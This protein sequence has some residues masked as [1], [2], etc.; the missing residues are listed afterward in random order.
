MMD[1]EFVVGLDA[2]DNMFIDLLACKPISCDIPKMFKTVVTF[3]ECSS[4]GLVFQT[5]WEI[6]NRLYEIQSTQVNIINSPIHGIP[7]WK[8][9]RYD[10]NPNDFLICLKRTCFSD[11]FK[12]DLSSGEHYVID[13]RVEFEKIGIL[14]QMV[15]VLLDCV[16]VETEISIFQKRARF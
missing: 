6:Y 4:S 7:S 8:H 15:L 13:F 5:N 2:E 14:N 16:L 10:S 12:V 9:N 11:D 3:V 1:V